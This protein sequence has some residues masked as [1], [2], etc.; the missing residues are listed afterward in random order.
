MNWW[1]WLFGNQPKYLFQDEFDGPAGSPP[2][3]ATWT[4]QLDGEKIDSRATSFQD[5]NSNLVI[6]VVNND[7]WYQTALISTGG[8]VDMHQDSLNPSFAGGKGTT[9]EARI[10][11]DQ[12][13]GTVAAFWMCGTRSQFWP[14]CGEVDVIEVFG[15]GEWWPSSTVHNITNTEG[16]YAA[17]PSGNP[18]DTNWHT[19]RMVWGADGGFSFYQD[20]A[21]GVAPYLVVPYNSLS[22]WPWPLDDSNKLFIILNQSVGGLGGGPERPLEPVDMLVDW[23]RVWRI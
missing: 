3:P 8:Q 22:G 20:Y 19:Y 23:V 7:G 4:H 16:P 15:N 5:G 13:P 14:E 18:M 17:P 9:W 21:P 1:Y 12:T 2:D 10:K 6:R 11:F